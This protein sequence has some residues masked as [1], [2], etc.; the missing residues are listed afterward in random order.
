MTWEL[1]SWA[2]EDL[3]S[4]HHPKAGGSEGILRLA[5]VWVVLETTPPSVSCNINGPFQ[6]IPGCQAPCHDGS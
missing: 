2:G 3:L 6:K 1:L 5:A 4:S